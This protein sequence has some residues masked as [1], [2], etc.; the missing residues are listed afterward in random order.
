M[1]QGAVDLD[2]R[3]GIATLCWSDKSRRNAISA[4]MWRRIEEYAYSIRN[5]HDIRVVILSGANNTFSAGANL[6]DF[7]ELRKNAGNAFDYDDIVESACASIEGLPQ[8]VI[9]AVS[10]FCYGAGLS[11]ACSSDLVIA[12]KG[13]TFAQPAGTLGIGYDVRGIQRL[14]RSAGP[15]L[16]KELMF[17][18]RQISAERM[19]TLGYVST[20][21]EHAEIETVV[22]EYAT[23]IASNAPLT[24][25]A[26][27]VA[28]RALVSGGAL[29]EA[30]QL[31]SLADASED[32]AEGRLAFSQKRSPNFTGK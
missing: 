14:V 4:A 18:A 21:V 26:A 30:I 17:T 25:K 8:P 20:L 29:E 3:S 31:T 13:A 28:V 24:L 32:Y 27:K 5:N 22:S 6:D 10:G 16:T 7:E 1:A 12:A 2:F 23:A 11:L 15:R 19:Y 9:A